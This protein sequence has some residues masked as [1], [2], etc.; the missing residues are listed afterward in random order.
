[1]ALTTGYESG[2]GGQREMGGT[3]P[4]ASEQS[5]KPD[6]AV[7]PNYSGPSIAEKRKGKNIRPLSGD[8]NWNRPTTEKMGAQDERRADEQFK[9]DSAGDF[10]LAT[11]ESESRMYGKR[12]TSLHDKK[13]SKTD[14]GLGNKGDSTRPYS[15]RAWMLAP[16]DS[17]L[18]T[19]P[20]MAKRSAKLDA[21]DVLGHS[22]NDPH[23]ASSSGSGGLG[24]NISEDLKDARAGLKE[25][26]ESA[27]QSMSDVGER[28]KE[29][30]EEL[31]EKTKKQVREFRT[32][33]GDIIEEVTTPVYARSDDGMYPTSDAKNAKGGV[34]VPMHSPDVAAVSSGASLGED[35][36]AVRKSMF[37]GPQ[38]MP[39]GV[40]KRAVDEKGR[41][42]ETGAKGS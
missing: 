29:G 40:G 31:W 3:P 24:G 13:F 10:G 14:A 28:V 9:K 33:A 6:G 25:G 20:G 16:R 22:H 42:M 27:K 36:N 19:E 34:Q 39:Q 37:D 1:M 11:D 38:D 23:P 21:D 41:P 7:L 30:A 15:T 32:S 26:M 18:N 35:V 17:P 5:A 12:A 8:D 2:Y 4:S